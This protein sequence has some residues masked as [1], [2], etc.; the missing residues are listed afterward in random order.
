MLMLGGINM[1]TGRPR[2]ALRPPLFFFPIFF[3]PPH[4]FNGFLPNPSGWCLAGPGC[5]RRQD[6]RGLCPLQGSHH[7]Q[8]VTSPS[9][10]EM[11]RRASISSQGSS[12]WLLQEQGWEAGIAGMLLLVGFSALV[13]LAEL[14][15][16]GAVP[17]SGD[18]DKS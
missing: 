1:H 13:A 15:L 10:V 7:H 11:G 16:L 4:H 5:H 6:A 9:G 14:G 2:D 18:D 17:R 8:Q 12:L 3:T